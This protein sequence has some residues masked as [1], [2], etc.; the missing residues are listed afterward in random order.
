MELCKCL[1]WKGYREQRQN[2]EEVKAA[3]RRNAVPYS[4]MFSFKPWGPDGDVVAPE[5]C[6]AKRSCYQAYYEAPSARLT[7]AKKRKNS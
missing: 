4:C 5:W 3:F 7:E 6:N 1:R 2:P